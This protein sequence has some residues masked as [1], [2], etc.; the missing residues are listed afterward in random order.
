MDLIEKYS[1]LSLFL[2]NTTVNRKNTCDS[3]KR[4]E[5][6]ITK[7]TCQHCKHIFSNTIRLKGHINVCK[8]KHSYTMN[9]LIEKIEKQDIQNEIYY[10][11]ID[12]LMQKEENV[13][14]K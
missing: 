13:T 11:K 12:I 6:K 7:L 2:S 3:I 1:L 9:S 14:K 10:K 4:E 5:Q 8:Q